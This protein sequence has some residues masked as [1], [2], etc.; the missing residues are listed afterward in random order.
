MF[1][2]GSTDPC[3]QTYRGT[4]AQSEVENDAL[5]IYLEEM[6][7][8]ERFDLLLTFHSYGAWLILPWGYTTEFDPEDT[9]ELVHAIFF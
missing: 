9:P 7:D 3:S 4:S 6:E 2:T 1:I 8:S 5:D